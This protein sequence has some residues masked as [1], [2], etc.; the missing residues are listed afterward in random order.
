MATY[1]DK[2][3]EFWHS[4]GASENISGIS[5]GA[6][7]TAFLSWKKAQKR[8]EQTEDE[9]HND[10]MGGYL[11]YMKNRQAAK[12]CGEFVP[13]L[14]YVSTF[15]NSDRFEIEDD[16]PTSEYVSMGSSDKCT[17]K[18]CDEDPI[19]YSHDERLCTSH[20]LAEFSQVELRS[21]FDELIERFGQKKAEQ[22]WMDWS[23]DLIEKIGL[24]EKSET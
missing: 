3:N 14:P 9:F 15:L 21:S 4:Y 10:V 16:V 24:L 13:K 8:R 11:A 23:M 22:T 2:F 18:N 12:G 5:K 1:T 19:Y 7:S 17:V 20:Y 6:K